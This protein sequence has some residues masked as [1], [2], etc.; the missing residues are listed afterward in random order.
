MKPTVVWIT[1]FSG[2]GKSTIANALNDKC[3]DN[4]CRSAVADSDLLRLDTKTPVGFDIEGRWKA[5][6][7]MIYAVR[8]MIEFQRAEIVIVT[9]IS[10]LRE[11]RDLARD[12]LTKYSKVNFIEV[13]VD[14][15]LQ[16]CEERDPKG[17]YRKFRSGLVKDMSGIDSPYERP[18]LPEVHLHHETT[19]GKMTV[20]RAVDIIYNR[21]H[22][23]TII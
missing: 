3:R 16:V 2:A 10:P 17:L 18:I 15:P 23:T 21:I 5:V 7:A 22:N 19:L 6:N 13:F 1:G 4:G 20:E 8:N 11:M 9:C 12:I 14:T